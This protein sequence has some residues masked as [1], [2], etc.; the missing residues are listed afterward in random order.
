MTNLSI[1]KSIAPQTAEILATEQNI[2]LQ[3]NDISV[4][5]K[6]EH[7]KSREGALWI[8]FLF[9]YSTT[10]ERANLLSNTGNKME[11][12]VKYLTIVSALSVVDRLQTFWK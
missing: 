12:T 7:N 11:H 3:K 9:L 8:R 10:N 5:F 2:V 4:N 6:H 1:P